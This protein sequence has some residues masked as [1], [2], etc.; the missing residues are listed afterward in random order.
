MAEQ[1]RARVDLDPLRVP[2]R[3]PGRVINEL[4]NHALEAQP[5]ECCGLVTGHA[6]ERFATVYRCHNEMSARHRSDPDAYPRDGTHGFVIN[7]GDY[8]R[9]AQ[10]AE[11]RG[12]QVT[13][14]YHSH[15]GAGV[16]F[17]ELDQE[18]A[19]SAFFPF[20]EASHLV[21]A[22]WEQRV[23]GAGIFDRDPS[24]GHYVGALIEVGE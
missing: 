9:A 4:C 10:D 18:F 14:V 11:G 21:L 20:P 12:E 16:Y 8:L 24:S 2:V 15:V 23:S 6:G 3:I 19:D 13:A 1:A 5:E 17:S 7:E 22:V